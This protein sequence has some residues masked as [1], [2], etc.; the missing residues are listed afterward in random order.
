[1]GHNLSPYLMPGFFPYLFTCSVLNPLHIFKLLLKLPVQIPA[2]HIFSCGQPGHLSS[3]A[4][5]PNLRVLHFH[6]KLDSVPAFLA[7]TQNCESRHNCTMIFKS[8]SAIGTSIL[9]SKPLSFAFT[10]IP[11]LVD[12]NPSLHTLGHWYCFDGGHGLLRCT[13]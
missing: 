6:F 3:C 5:Y 2:F 4:Y 8:L 11:S 9:W 10:S 1:M 13:R 7:L 12:L